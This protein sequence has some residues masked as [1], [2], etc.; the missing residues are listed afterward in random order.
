[1]KLRS[2]LSRNINISGLKFQ[3]PPTTEKLIDSEASSCGSGLP[4]KKM[5]PESSSSQQPIGIS[6]SSSKMDMTSAS[7]LTGFFK[8]ESNRVLQKKSSATLEQTVTSEY[9][10]PDFAKGEIVNPNSRKGKK[11]RLKSFGQKQ[12]LKASK[13]FMAFERTKEERWSKVA[14]KAVE[15]LHWL[16]SKQ[17]YKQRTMLT[18]STT[19][20]TVEISLQSP[21]RRNHLATCKRVA[22]KQYSKAAEKVSSLVHRQQDVL[23]QEPVSDCQIC[24]GPMSESDLKHPLQC[25]TPQCYF[26]F[27]ASCIQSLIKSSE[28]AYMVGSDGSRQVKVLLQCPTCR[29]D[30]SKSIR[31]TLLLRTADMTLSHSVRN[32]ILL[33]LLHGHH[34]DSHPANKEKSMKMDTIETEICLAR[35]EE[36]E[37]FKTKP[38]SQELQEPA[39]SQNDKYPTRSE[40]YK[41]FQGIRERYARYNRALNPIENLTSTIRR[42]STETR[43]LNDEQTIHRSDVK[44]IRS[45]IPIVHHPSFQSDRASCFYIDTHMNFAGLNPRLR[46]QL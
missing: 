37:F 16:A 5:F 31:R 32:A 30:L 11:D 39:T 34:P 4:R 6:L 38:R 10:T 14:T 44:S 35:L 23:P 19:D 27:C 45:P 36:R 24:F 15:K 17:H 3:E 40:H 22:V 33:H 2:P 41:H 1:M 42:R 18:T 7:L 9:S 13:T 21:P 43:R 20:D 25:A 29:C 8:K 46:F 26:N 12:Y 28:D